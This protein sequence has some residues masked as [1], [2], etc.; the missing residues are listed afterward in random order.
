[1]PEAVSRKMGMMSADASD[2]QGPR[3]SDHAQQRAAQRRPVGS[4]LQ[5]ARRAGKN[6]VF[7]QPDDGRFVVRGPKGREHIFEPDGQIVTSLNRPEAAHRRKMSS[8]ERIPVTEEDF[9]RL[10]GLIHE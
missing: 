6:D 2:D 5:D 9:N 3:R 1:M 10:K 4:A 7:V 8:G